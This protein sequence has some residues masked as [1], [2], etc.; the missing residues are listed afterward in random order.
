LQGDQALAN[1]RNRGDRGDVRV[2]LFAAQRLAGIDAV[3]ANGRVEAVDPALDIHSPQRLDHRGA[4][5]GIDAELQELPGHRAV[6][7]AG[8]HHDQPESLG[9]ESRERALSGGGGS[10]DGDGA[11]EDHTGTVGRS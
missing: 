9:K 11:M 10:V 4:V 8:I 3:D 1:L 6:H 7:R 2:H 5:G